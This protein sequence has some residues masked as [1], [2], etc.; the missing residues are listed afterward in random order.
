M[1]VTGDF[2]RSLALHDFYG[3]NTTQVCQVSVQLYCSIP[4]DSLANAFIDW[5]QQNQIFH[6]HLLRSST[7][8]HLPKLEL[9]SGQIDKKQKAIIANLI[10]FEGIQVS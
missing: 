10:H 6:L 8:S 2:V 9:H 4:I 1:K 7:Y 5:I 3:D